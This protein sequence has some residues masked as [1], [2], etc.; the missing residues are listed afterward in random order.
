MKGKIERTSNSAHVAGERNSGLSRREP[1][2]GLMNRIVQSPRMQQQIATIQAVFGSTAQRQES[3]ASN[4]NRT[5]MP[6]QLKSGV[7]ALSGMSMNHVRVH[8]NSDRPAR[9]NAL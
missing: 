9:L 8:Y 2:A 3:A 4:L 7:E 1:P 5:G 6:D